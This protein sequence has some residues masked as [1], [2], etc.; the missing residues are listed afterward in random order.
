M[1]PYFSSLL[2]ELYGPS[3][4]GYQGEVVD[5]LLPAD[6][7]SS[8]SIVRPVDLVR[9]A[10]DELAFL[11][12]KERP[13]DAPRALDAT[14]SATRKGFDASHLVEVGIGCESCHGGSR[15]HV[16]DFR[17]KPSFEI[18]STFVRALPSSWE[19]GHRPA[20]RARAVDRVC[21]RCHQVLFSRYPFTWEGGHRNGD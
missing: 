7:R 13:D 2:G 9:A 4:P 18:R 5:H 10:G 6:R 1:A 20:E 15:E 21:A 11:G 17:T 12:A 14:L 8:L 3:A 19:T 16:A